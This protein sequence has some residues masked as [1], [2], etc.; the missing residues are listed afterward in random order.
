MFEKERDNVVE[1][2]TVTHPYACLLAIG[3]CSAGVLL[4]LIK[5]YWY[6][7]FGSPVVLFLG[8]VGYTT[9]RLSVTCKDEHW[10]QPGRGARLRRKS[11]QA[12]DV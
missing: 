2:F 7:L 1:M 8:I 5:G 11:R 6:A 9:L 3:L 12:V 4:L 10:R